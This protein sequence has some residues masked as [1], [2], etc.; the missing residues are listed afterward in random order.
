MIERQGD[1]LRVQGP[2]TMDGIMQARE[3]GAALLSGEAVVIDLGAVTDVDS[4][5]LSLLLE[6]QR[7]ARRRNVRIAIDNL[8]ENLKSL[9]TLY[10]VTDLVA[11]NG[12]AG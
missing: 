8:P 12:A 3:A 11:A 4:S 10:G 9:A 7:E 1:R 5:A 2:L 6:W